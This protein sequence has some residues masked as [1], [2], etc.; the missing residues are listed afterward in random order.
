M[1]FT[2]RRNTLI[3]LLVLILACPAFSLASDFVIPLEGQWRFQLDR[4]DKGI[5]EKWFSK[6][7]EGQIRLPGSLQEQGRIPSGEDP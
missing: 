2:D 1:V 4:E 3:F 6:R 7:L 5:A